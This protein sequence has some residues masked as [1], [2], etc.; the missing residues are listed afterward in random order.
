MKLVIVSLA[1]LA[2]MVMAQNATGTSSSMFPSAS[3]AWLSDVV[4]LQ[5]NAQSYPTGPVPTG[6]FSGT[7]NLTGYPTTWATPPTNSP[8]VQNAINAINWGLVP[9]STVRSASSN[10]NLNFGGYDSAND[11]DCWWSATTCTSPKHQGVPTDIVN[12]PIPGT[13]GLTYDDGPLTSDGGQYA[14]PNLY[15]FLANNGNQ[16]ADLFYIGSNVITAPL[17]AQRALADGHTL[18]VHT[19]SHPP[20][21]TKQNA[22]VVAEFY[23][24]LH[25][26]KEVT[27]VT[28]KCW[29]PP[30][31]DVDDRVRAIAAQMGMQT[32]IWDEDTDDWNMPG[33]GGGNLPPSTVDGY[34]EG[35]IQARQNGTDNVSG[36]I[37][38]EHELNNATV[39][40]AEKWLPQIQKVFRVVPVSQCHNVTH[41]YWET[42]FT[43]PT[44]A[45]PNPNTTASG[46]PSASSSKPSSSSSA[47]TTT[48]AASTLTVSSALIVGL[49]ALSATLF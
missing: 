14:E 27:G 12:C 6:P 46:T 37:V 30:Y 45:N 16:K 18:C 25:A 29:R 33:S 4:P 44:D 49:L 43:Y 11:P 40:M 26:I 36:H 24:T 22:E 42:A 9:N 35:W 47:S 2:S 48:S 3:P 10:G 17:A 41:P 34:F 23:W 1:S 5:G 15:D 31:G 21:T 19:W 28:P 13:W 20:M 8:Q 38:L 32:I 39:T 7:I